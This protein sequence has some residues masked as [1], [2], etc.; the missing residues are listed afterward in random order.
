MKKPEI[1]QIELFD[2]KIKFSGST[3]S[4]L[5]VNSIVLY[6]DVNPSDVIFGINLKN[7][8][9]IKVDNTKK[10]KLIKRYQTLILMSTLVN[11]NTDEYKLML[12]EILKLKKKIAI[13]V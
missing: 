12:L 7:I 10:Q 13:T 9:I 6:K 4:Q 5:S 11:K 3:V 8:K 2:G 1:K